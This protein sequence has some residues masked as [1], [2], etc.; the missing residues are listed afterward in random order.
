MKKIKLTQNKYALVDDSDFENL[1]KFKWS[2]TQPVNVFYAVRRV[3]KKLVYMHRVINKTPI[4]LSTDH[5]DG[6][7]LNNQRINLRVCSQ[8]QNCHNGPRYKN[9]SSG[10]KGVCWHKDAKKW[11]AYIRNGGKLL[12]LG[13]FTSKLKA[14]KAYCEASI[15]YHKEFSR[16]Y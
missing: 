8:A 6:N 15:K 1:N 11:M 12:N 9:N 16:I 13:L 3:G 10:Y 2:A 5:I 14:F 7:G 4:N